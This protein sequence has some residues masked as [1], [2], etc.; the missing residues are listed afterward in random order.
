MKFIALLRGINV[1]GKNTIKMSELKTCFE[2]MGFSEVTTYINSGNVIFDSEMS[3]STL[4]EIIER[5]IKDYFRLEIFVV[6]K[7]AAQI[8]K[9]IE[10]IPENWTNDSKMRTDILF[11]FPEIDRSEVLNEIKSNPD[12]DNLRYFPGAVVWN[13][14]R[15]NYNK[16]KLHDL[17]GSKIYKKT[18][19]RNVNTVRKIHEL[20]NHE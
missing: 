19:I 10:E 1:G 2:K 16:S 13:V 18:T 14:D 15:V 5:S 6:I 8:K 17:I 7:S 4:V 12:F 20:M 11:L 9:L 3:E